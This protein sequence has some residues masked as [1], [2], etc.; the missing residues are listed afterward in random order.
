MI[1]VKYDSP[2]GKLTLESDGTNLTAIL[3]PGEQSRARAPESCEGNVPVLDSARCQLDQYF[4][5]RLQTFDLPL[6]PSGTDF[7]KQVWRRLIKIPYGQTSTYA[8]LAKMIGQPTA[9]R[10]VGAA[11]GRNPLPIVIPCHRVIGSS[12][13]LT[14]YAGGLEAK[15]AL[16]ELE[17]AMVK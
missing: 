3:F 9:C 14:G 1:A 12:G 11:N 10:A 5:G 7:Q 8:E 15:Q 6:A 13:K 4:A 16:L 17:G 2:L